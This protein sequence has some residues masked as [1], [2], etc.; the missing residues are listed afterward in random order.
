MFPEPDLYVFNCLELSVDFPY[1]TTFG[2]F[3]YCKTLTIEIVSLKTDVDKQINK[4]LQ[5]L[6]EHC[7]TPFTF[8]GF[9][10]KDILKE[11]GVL[12]IFF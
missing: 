12:N 1:E 9:H 4:A 6:M 8:K 2:E 10:E 3:W 7:S 5:T 11:Q